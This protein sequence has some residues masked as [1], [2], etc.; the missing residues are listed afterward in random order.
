MTNPKTSRYLFLMGFVPTLMVAALVLTCTF[1]GL[2]S[3]GGAPIQ[4]QRS[5]NKTK[6]DT[7]YVEKEVIKYIDSNPAPVVH[8]P[9]VK[10]Q[11]VVKPQPV[12]ST[13]QSDTI[14]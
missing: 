1:Y 8:K 7:V 6:P 5:D 14:Q 9:A 10:P 13:P 2:K 3:N 4:I 12:D 11:L